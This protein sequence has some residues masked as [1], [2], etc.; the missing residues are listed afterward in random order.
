ME[1]LFKL[2]YAML[3]HI[4]HI[5]VILPNSLRYHSGLTYDQYISSLVNLISII[6]DK[7]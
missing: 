2:L 7:R 1:K 5:E 3:Y 6:V 4:P